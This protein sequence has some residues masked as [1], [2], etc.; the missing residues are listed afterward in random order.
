M[1]MSALLLATTATACSSN[2]GADK[3]K[4]D[5]PQPPAP[6][7]FDAQLRTIDKAK[8]VDTQMLNRVNDLN[9]Q[10]DTSADG[11]APAKGDA[12]AAGDSH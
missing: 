6:T 9:Q 2:S 5:Q 7:V 3:A 10:I 1:W 4:A 12:N 8:A 11:A